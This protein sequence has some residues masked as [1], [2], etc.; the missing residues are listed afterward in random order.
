MIR[1]TRIKRVSARMSSR[2]REY[3]KAKK[4][5]LKANPVC[6]VDNCGRPTQDVHHM[7]G[8]AGLLLLEER[9]WLPVCRAHHDWIH[10]YPEEARIM[11]WLGP[12]GRRDD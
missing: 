12:W 1:R 11:G 8:R 6:T 2:L 7:R 5:W 9:W 10:K 4:V 3:A